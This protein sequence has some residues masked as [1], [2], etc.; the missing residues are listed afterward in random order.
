MQPAGN[1]FLNVAH[2]ILDV[3]T[4]G[5]AANDGFKTRSRRHVGVGAGIE[6]LAIAR[7]AK[8]QPVVGVVIGE[9]FRDALDRLHQ[10]LLA[11]LACVL[12]LLECGNVVNPGHPLAADKA[13]M[14]A[15][16]G[17]LR[18][19]DQHV[20]RL[21]LLGFPEHLVIG[22]SAAGLPAS[23]QIRRSRS[24]RSCQNLRVSNRS[25]SCSE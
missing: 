10:P 2:G 20:N 11:A 13:D 4:L 16:I 9:A 8:H 7:I 5:G 25:I 15:A 3:A 14:A 19:R 23:F 17:D 24:S 12:R 6:H 1:P 21:A 22:N 18:V